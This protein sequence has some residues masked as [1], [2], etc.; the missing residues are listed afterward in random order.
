MWLDESDFSDSDPTVNPAAHLEPKL[1]MN[2][3]PHLYLFMH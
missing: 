3:S 2:R 1:P